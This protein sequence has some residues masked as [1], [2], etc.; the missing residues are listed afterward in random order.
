MEKKSEKKSAKIEELNQEISILENHAQ[1]EKKNLN[2]SVRD[3]QDRMKA[4]H[5]KQL[6]DLETAQAEVVQQKDAEISQL[7]KSLQEIT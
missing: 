4:R 6:L 5:A 2:S 7:K 1:N 3:K